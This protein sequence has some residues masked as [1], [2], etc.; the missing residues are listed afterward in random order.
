MIGDYL[1]VMDI[2]GISYNGTAWEK[3]GKEVYAPLNNVLKVNVKEFVNTLT[4]D[5]SAEEKRDYIIKIFDKL[6]I[7]DFLSLSDKLANLDKER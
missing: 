3:K 4:G 7:G 1:T 5:K 6:T 2:L